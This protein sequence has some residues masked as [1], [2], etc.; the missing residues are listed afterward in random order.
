MCSL[1]TVI[2][3]P[4]FEHVWCRLEEL[5]EECST[6]LQTERMPNTRVES[7]RFTDVSAILKSRPQ[8]CLPVQLGLPLPAQEGGVR[9]G[10]GDG[11]GVHRMEVGVHACMVG[12]KGG[13]GWHQKLRPQTLQSCCMELGHTCG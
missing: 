6:A 7:F 11:D 9:G 4:E 1:P 8:V 13:V 5:H 2:V 10:M 3:L 12:E